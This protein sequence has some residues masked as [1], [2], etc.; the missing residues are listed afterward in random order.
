M[1]YCVALFAVKTCEPIVRGGGRFGE[2]P[3][4][5]VFE[6]IMRAVAD[7]ARKMGVPEMVMTPPGVRVGRAAASIPSC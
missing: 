2:E 3:I 6:P 4:G 5:M 1:S 7:G